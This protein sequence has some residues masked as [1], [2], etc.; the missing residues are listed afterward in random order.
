[1]CLPSATLSSQPFA[2][3]VAKL[4]QS[5]VATRPKFRT[6]TILVNWVRISFMHSYGIN[7]QSKHFENYLMKSEE[8]IP[9]IVDKEE[10]IQVILQEIRMIKMKITNARKKCQKKQGKLVGQN[11]SAWHYTTKA[12]H[13]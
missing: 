4:L 13:I 2:N 1:M 8:N 10:V 3:N 9:S 6:L 5:L 11:L 7:L 12:T